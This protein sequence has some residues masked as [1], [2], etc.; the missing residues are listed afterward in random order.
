MVLATNALRGLADLAM[1]DGAMLSP[2]PPLPA[3]KRGRPAAERSAHFGRATGLPE[4]HEIIA[5][6]MYPSLD[7]R[8]NRS[9]APRAGLWA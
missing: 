3:A 9:T 1:G 2:L 5:K 4:F 6:F 7:W 8:S